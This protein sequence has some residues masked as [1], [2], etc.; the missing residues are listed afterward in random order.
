MSARRQFY[1]ALEALAVQPLGPEWVGDGPTLTAWVE[2]RG[3]G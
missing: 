3:E 1:A 2:V